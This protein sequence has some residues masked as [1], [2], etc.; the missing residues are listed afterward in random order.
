[1]SVTGHINV[2]FVGRLKSWDGEARIEPRGPR[3][4]RQRFPMM[5]ERTVSRSAS[6]AGGSAFP[7]M[8]EHEVIR[9]APEA[10]GS[11]FLVKGRSTWCR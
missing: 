3:R 10:G 1:M 9:A 7:V 6:T 2:I 4:R 5:G 8:G 11:A